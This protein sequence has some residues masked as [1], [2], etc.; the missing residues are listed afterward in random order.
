MQRIILG[1]FL[2]IAC[3]LPGSARERSSAA[4][5]LVGMW[6]IV[7]YSQTEQ[8][9]GVVRFANDRPSG[10]LVYTKNGR[11]VAWVTRNNRPAADLVPSDEVR[12]AWQKA[13]IAGYSGRYT[14]KPGIV[15]H[16]VESAWN[17]AWVGTDQV[18]RY[19]LNGDR[20]VI[21]TMPYRT[22]FDGKMIVSR[23]VFRRVA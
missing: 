15:T 12:V 5:S 10:H 8:D 6:E 21:H 23:L 3:A 14:L 19:E 9:S 16:H 1:L 11:M 22:S 20:L 7:E 18:R 13:I 17:P 4:R 2:I